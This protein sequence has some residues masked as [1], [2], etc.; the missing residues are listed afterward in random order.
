MQIDS[1]LVHS[2][3][4]HKRNN[5]TQSCR[6]IPNLFQKVFFFENIF[7]LLLLFPMSPI[8]GQWWQWIY[9]MSELN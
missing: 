2:D 9:K 1:M 8:F 5:L 3:K 7:T 6:F 4:F